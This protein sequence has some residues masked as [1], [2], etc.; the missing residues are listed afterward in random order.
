MSLESHFTIAELCRSAT[1][2]ELGI[3]NKP[4]LHVEKNLRWTIA[5]LERVR[6]ILGGHPIKVHSG[7]R[8]PTLNRE[9]GGV[10]GS[11]HLHGQAV[12]FT[13][14]KFG[15]PRA[16]VVKLYSWVEVLGIDQLILEPSWVHVSFTDTPRGEVLTLSGG[17]YVQGIV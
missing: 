5:G 1:A 15:D 10:E 4:P 11:K 16:I 3:D 13:C 9:V 17:V 8:C 12:D 2:R 7:Y 6:A 14:A